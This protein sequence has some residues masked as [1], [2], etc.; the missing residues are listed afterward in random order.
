MLLGS[1]LRFSL[2]LSLSCKS[3]CFIKLSLFDIGCRDADTARKIEIY[4]SIPPFFKEMFD[5]ELLPKEMGGK[6][7][8]VIPYPIDSKKFDEKLITHENDCEIF[9]H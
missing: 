4:S 9:E 6:N 5:T 8:T 2:S 3:L 1:C 7:D